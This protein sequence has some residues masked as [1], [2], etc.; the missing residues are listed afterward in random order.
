MRCVALAVT[1][2][3]LLC[4]GLGVETSTPAVG[5]EVARSGAIT[6]DRLLDEMTDMRRL[7]ELP[8]PAYTTKQFSSYDRKSKSPAEDWFAN[9][10]FNQ[11][12]R[13]EEVDG[14]KE[15][16]MMDTDGPGVI[17]RIWSA[18][19]KGK[20]RIYLD[21]SS[22]PAIEGGMDQLLGGSYR[23]L[24]KPIAGERSRGWNLYFPI[25]YA[26]HCKVTSDQPGFY[27]HINYRTYPVGTEV[28]SFE[29]SDLERLS[30]Q[31]QAVAQALSEPR[32]GSDPPADRKKTP[33]EATLA[34]DASAVLAELKGS[35][36]IC[37]LLFHIEAEDLAK[38]A[39]ATVLDITFDGEKT[40]ECPLGDFYSTV[41]G[42]IPY[43][44][45]PLGVTDTKPADLYCH[46][47][48][49][50]AR[51]VKIAVR[52]LGDQE[53]RVWGAV[54]VVPQS[55]TD[56]SL[57]FHAKWRT[58]RDVPARPMTDW[59]HLEVQGKGRFVGGNLHIVNS[60][61]EWWGEGDEKIYVDGEKFPSHFGTGTEDYY[62]Y[63]WCS[64]D[65]FVHAYHNQPRCQGPRNY[66]HT[67]VSRFHIIDDIPF[68][69][70]FKFDIENW[71]GSARPEAKTT[72]AAASY[73][74]A[75]PGATDFFKPLTREDVRLINPPPFKVR[76]VAGAIE[77][78]KMRVLEKTGNAGPQDYGDAFSNDAQLWW[79]GGKVGDKLVL[80]F[81]SQDA[82]RK[83]VVVQL[84]K[85]PDYGIVQLY[86]NGEK[87]G[88]P[89]DLY[90]PNVIQAGEKDLGAFE[91]K[92]GRN[93]LTVEIVGTNEKAKKEY[94]F[95]MDYMLLK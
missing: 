38:A 93:T 24:P 52:N 15:H 26:K 42:L 8:E 55:W 60:V 23:G 37:G 90:H 16:V 57:L 49:P 72:R 11:F 45:I 68:A 48:M 73:W 40:V 62:G 31:I 95:G 69:S 12:L 87:A 51:D 7:A 19:P 58:Q 53:V 66:G 67:I 46:W 71:H 18:N 92:T 33:F 81:R 34:P 2:G 76:E 88:E 64:P 79:T 13:I 70:S 94:M 84:T 27:Y 43:A 28:K 41:P 9:G 35:L 80:A 44:S 20:I 82:A 77:G 29:R 21:G 54:A 22:T 65:R 14:R 63:A 25:P 32:K 59:A 4:G 1:I 3:L 75:R 85:A 89:I 30:S 56:R 78:E 36:A 74:Y 5:Q 91:L 17:V 61:R 10:D 47:W 6:V 50:F 83:H 39:R 86:I